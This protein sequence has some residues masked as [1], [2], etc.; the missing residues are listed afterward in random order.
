MLYILVQ[1]LSITLYLTWFKNNTNLPM[2]VFGLVLRSLVELKFIGNHP[3]RSNRPTIDGLF[4][5]SL[6]QVL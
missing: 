3:S 6:D 4:I 5:I 2:K 1:I